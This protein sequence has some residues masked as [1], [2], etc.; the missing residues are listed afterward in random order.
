ME[1]P[2]IKYDPKRWEYIKTNLKKLDYRIL[3]L[4][5][6]EFCP[7]I[8]LDLRG[9]IGKCSN[10]SERES[11][12]RYEVTDAEEFLERAAILIGKQYKRKD[13]VKING[14]EIKPGM[15]IYV[16]DT[17]SDNLYIVIPT[18]K[19]LGVISYGKAHSWDYINNFLKENFQNIVAVSD[20]SE[21]A[22]AD[23][24][25]WEKSKEVVLTMQEIADKFGIPIKQ[26]KITK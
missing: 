10:L 18:K 20:I 6:W 22:L 19:G 15:G 11:S 8:V 14:I 23:N 24:I 25:I 26:L 5:R 13:M 12:N 9:E 7:Y 1:T 21:D 3:C 4:S 17:T 16:N 2:R